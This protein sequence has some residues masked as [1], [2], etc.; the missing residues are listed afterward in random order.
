[1]LAEAGIELGDDHQLTQDE[2]L[3]GITPVV[4]GIGDAPALNFRA[5]HLFDPASTPRPATFPGRAR[6]Q[7]LKP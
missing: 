4:Q 6:A 3:M 2:F 1:V 7:R 5:T